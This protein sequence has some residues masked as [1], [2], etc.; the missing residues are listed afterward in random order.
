MGTLILL[1]YIYIYIC[2]ES[3]VQASDP[4]KFMHFKEKLFDVYCMWFITSGQDMTNNI[5]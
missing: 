3:S 1:I 5:H 4:S 2:F